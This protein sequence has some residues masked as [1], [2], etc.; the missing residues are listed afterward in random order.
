M[1]VWFK[2]KFKGCH[3]CERDKKTQ[4]FI[5]IFAVED[6]NHRI[7]I[8]SAV[9]GSVPLYQEKPA[10]FEWNDKIVYICFDPYILKR[11]KSRLFFP[12]VECLT[13]KKPEDEIAFDLSWQI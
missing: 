10:T 3:Y 4:K 5:Y 13:S 9:E 12:E 1:K 6:H 8:F 2:V 11:Y 7:R